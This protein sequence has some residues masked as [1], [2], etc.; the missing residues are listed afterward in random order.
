MRFFAILLCLVVVRAAVG[1]DLCA[2]YNAGSA[3]GESSAGFSLAVAEQYIPYRTTQVDGEEV[4]L[5]NASYVDNSITHLVPGYT[6]GSRFG[7]SLNVPFVHNNFKR[8]DVRYSLTAP[9]VFFTEKGTEFGLGDLALIGRLTLFQK[10]EMDYSFLFTILAGAKFPT[11]DDERLDDEVEQSEIFASFL[12]PGTPHDPLGH[13][14]GSVHQ[15]SLALGSG[16]YDGIF[17]ATFSARWQRW[18]LNAQFQYYLRTEGE[19]GFEY[20]DETMVSGGP[21]V[22][23]LLNRS[24]TLSL[25]ANAGYDTM[26]RDQ[27]LGTPSDRTGMTAW[28]LGPLLNFTYG[29]HLSANVGVDIPL[30]IDNNGFQSVPDYRLHGG[31]AWRF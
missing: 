13:S 12:P 14:V 6:F 10:Q 15:H 27:I 2:I 8:T 25:Q 16:S 9:P 24:F 22:F 20:G 17:G 1:C 29:A 4:D 18:F 21:G 26:A 11:G 19:S 5:P 23:V 31:L 30:R 7:V 28:Y 3:L